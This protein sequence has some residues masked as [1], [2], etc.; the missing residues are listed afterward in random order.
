MQDVVIIKST[1][2]FG[3]GIFNI[4]Q[5]KKEKNFQKKSAYGVIGLI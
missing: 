2:H 3:C 5:K 1:K 4:F